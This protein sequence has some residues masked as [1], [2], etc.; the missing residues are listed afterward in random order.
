L[1]T[2]FKCLDKNNDGKIS[3]EELK[4]SYDE[5]KIQLSDR[6]VDQMLQSIDADNSGFIDYA[7]FIRATYDKEKLLT[8]THLKIVFDTFDTDKNGKI[9][10]YDLRNMFGKNAND[11]V[12]SKLIK[13][14][15]SEDIDFE[16][17]SSIIRSSFTN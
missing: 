12:M 16:E 8:D 2:I 17:F 6:E 3:K 11:E 5:L 13:E 15:H 7:E 9:D 4:E 14:V 10:S 1:Q